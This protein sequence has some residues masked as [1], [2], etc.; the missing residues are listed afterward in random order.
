MQN[1]R[2]PSATHSPVRCLAALRDRGGTQSS[3]MYLFYPLTSS[4]S[5]SIP[6]VLLEAFQSLK[7]ESTIRASIPPEKK[8][9]T[10]DFTSRSFL[11]TDPSDPY[12]W[13]EVVDLLLQ[14]LASDRELK[15]W[16]GGGV[17]SHFEEVLVRMDKIAEKMKP[18]AE[19][20]LYDHVKIALNV[21]DILSE[22]LEALH[23]RDFIVIWKLATRNSFLID[24]L[25]FV[26]SN[27]TH[28]HPVF[29][30]VLLFTDQKT[31]TRT[32]RHTK[33]HSQSTA[34]P[35]DFDERD[36]MRLAHHILNG[37]VDG[38]F[39]ELASPPTIVEF[40]GD[41]LFFL[42][43]TTDV[44][45]IKAELRSFLTDD[46]L[47]RR[48]I[49]STTVLITADSVRQYFE[50]SGLNPSRFGI[51]MPGGLSLADLGL[52]IVHSEDNSPTLEGPTQYL[53]LL[54]ALGELGAD[55]L[56]VPHAELFQ[57]T[58]ER[59]AHLF[60]GI[61]REKL[62]NYVYDA[63]LWARGLGLILVSQYC[64][65]GG[66]NYLIRVPSSTLRSLLN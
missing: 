6:E 37:I 57:R 21:A 25:Q 45:E 24:I 30:P 1:S 22:L 53:A 62:V 49:R 64:A 12:S 17:K 15:E 8:A 58:E 5:N 54:R 44:S 46:Y 23:N 9:I 4:N 41:M 63:I 56:H 34:I 66:L 52:K 31:V 59:L 38:D 10:V 2:P 60:R 65:S 26:L 11:E 7:V 29:F 43:G 33:N 27:L 39:L 28:I 47:L 14:T 48:R 19:F 16:T 42:H 55:Q 51:S 40:F 20:T 18:D 32:L 35:I 13:R 36:G 61:T 50:K 3:C